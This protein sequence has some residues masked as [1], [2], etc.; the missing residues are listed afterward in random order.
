MTIPQTECRLEV[1]D[2]DPCM[3]VSTKPCNPCEETADV[4]FEP[5]DGSRLTAMRYQHLPEGPI[6]LPMPLPHGR[7]G[8]Y[9]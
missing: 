5:V 1:I 8:R 9:A 7:T 4:R 6:C 2:L 3:S